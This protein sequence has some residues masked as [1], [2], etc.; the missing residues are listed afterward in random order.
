ME[1]FTRRGALKLGGLGIASSAVDGFGLLSGS[2][3]S[4]SFRTAP[5]AALLE[6]PVL[7][8]GDGGLRVTLEVREGRSGWG[9]GRHCPQ[10][11][12]GLPRPTRRRRS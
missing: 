2:R 6:P 3:S 11:Q 1:T 12:R 5:G 7:R 4:S 9:Q 8:S 10:L